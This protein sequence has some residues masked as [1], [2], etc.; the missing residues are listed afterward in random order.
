MI[1][2]DFPEVVRAAERTF[3]GPDESGPGAAARAAQELFLMRRAAFSIAVHAVEMLRQRTGGIAGRRVILLVGAGKNG[4]D[5]LFA[6]VTLRERGAT[7]VA[8]QT[9][10]RIHAAGLAAFRD[11]GGQLVPC[12]DDLDALFAGADLVVDGILGS[13]ARPGL[14]PQ[15]RQVLAAARKV[16]PVLAVDLPSGID[17][18]TGAIP[19]PVAGADLTVACGGV[20]AGLL[21]PP[22]DALVGEIRVADLDFAPYLP[23]VSAV[24]RFQDDEISALWPIPERTE[25]KYSRGV[26]GV[27]AGSNAYPGAGVL[28]CLG[29]VRSGGGMVR[30]IGPQ[31]VKTL[32]VEHLPEVVGENPASAIGPHAK[33]CDAY[34]IGPGLLPEDATHGAA[35]ELCTTAQ[36][37]VIDAGALDIVPA[38][39]QHGDAGPVRPHVVLTPH[40]AEAA[41]LAERLG[42]AHDLAPAVLVKNLARATGTTVLLKGATTLIAPGDDPDALISQSDA[43]PALATA[44]AGDVLA[45][46]IGT[47]LAAGVDGPSAAAVGAAVHGRAARLAARVPSLNS[48]GAVPVQCGYSPEEMPIPLRASDVAAAIPTVLAALRDRHDEGPGQVAAQ[49]TYAR[50]GQVDRRVSSASGGQTIRVGALGR[51]DLSVRAGHTIRRTRVPRRA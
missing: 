5:A 10:D 33:K 13:G 25:T 9:M 27:F 16:A 44:G 18:R 7:V 39:D 20:M 37:A 51:R 47:L 17:P 48:G 43:T 41:R 36:R 28:A 42:V 8:V 50:D 12:P 22:A 6:G 15:L 19:E 35:R 23:A 21:L 49:G 11:S 2:A 30:Y 38:R 14:T 3:L 34:V 4:G 45:G 32:V 1:R 29:A 24:R 26:V 46:I 31:A 40:A